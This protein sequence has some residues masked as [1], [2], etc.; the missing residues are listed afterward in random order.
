MTKMKYI[1]ALILCAV[2]IF[3]FYK[4]KKGSGL[5]T[6]DVNDSDLR[7]GTVLLVALLTALNAL[8]FIFSSQALF[9]FVIWGAFMVLLICTAV[10]YYQSCRNVEL[11]MNLLNK[12]GSYKD[13]SDALFTGFVHFETTMP[14]RGFS[15]EKRIYLKGFKDFARA[16]LEQNAAL[17]EEEFACPAKNPPQK[18]SVQH[19]ASRN[20][21]R[22]V[23]DA[24][25]SYYSSAYEADV[26]G[27]KAD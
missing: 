13:I 16:L 5:C 27:F 12:A 25:D 8:N 17:T 10:F 15:E 21:V 7:I 3:S 23:F 19:A 11:I 9:P 20:G 18:R 1:I 14:P 2:A 24:S 22:M 4:I 26:R 6:K